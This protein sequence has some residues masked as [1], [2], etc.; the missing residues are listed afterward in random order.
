MYEV[1]TVVVS[2]KI[3]EVFETIYLEEVISFHL[4]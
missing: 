3:S 2:H 1:D 4:F